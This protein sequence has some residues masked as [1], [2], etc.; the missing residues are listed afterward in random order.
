MRKFFVLTIIM[1][2]FAVPV[3]TK[4]RKA[5]NSI[6][7]YNREIQLPQRQTITPI[8]SNQY[9]RQVILPAYRPEY[10]VPQILI[11][12]S[13]IYRVDYQ[14]FITI[15]PV[16]IYIQPREHDRP[17]RHHGRKK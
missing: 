1:C 11:P 10:K 5:I 12:P 2:I 17:H 16:Q 15:P 3:S 14:N 8:Y 9:N 4:D 6:N 13:N 7:P